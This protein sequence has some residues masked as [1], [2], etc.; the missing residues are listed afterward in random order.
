[1]FFD[2][3]DHAKVYNSAFNYAKLL[4]FS[5]ANPENKKTKDDS[6]YSY[7][8][9]SNKATSGLLEVAQSNKAHVYESTKSTLSSSTSTYREKMAA[10][11]GRE[12]AVRSEMS[13][14]QLQADLSFLKAYM[15][16]LNALLEA[17]VKT[18]AERL[19]NFLEI[20]V[21]RNTNVENL[22]T[23]SLVGSYFVRPFYDDG[24]YLS[25]IDVEK[26]Q[27]AEILLAPTDIV[28][29]I[30][31][32]NLIS[33]DIDKNILIIKGLDMGNNQHESYKRKAIGTTIYTSK[34]VVPYPDIMAINLNN[35]SYNKVDSTSIGEK[36]S[37]YS[38]V[39]DSMFLSAIKNRE[40]DQYESMIASGINVNAS[41]KY[42]ITALMYAALID[43]KKLVKSL[44]KNGA[45]ASVTDANFWMA[46]HYYFILNHMDSKS[47]LPLIKAARDEIK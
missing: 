29:M 30:N 45:R 42:G 43:D 15:G 35:L 13:M 33:F 16:M 3:I 4:A 31:Y 20:V 1:M 10:L 39:S 28:S 27:K 24:W 12:A 14:G 25:I 6:E 5:I 37:F 11:S 7:R 19:L 22:H 2:I 34:E 36:E 38:D 9:F 47:L 32:P 46:A 18:H 8:N 40:K 21:M 17:G 44:L 23:G 41:D 26:A